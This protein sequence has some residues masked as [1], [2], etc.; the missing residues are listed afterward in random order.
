MTLK[1]ENSRVVDLP[2]IPI[3]VEQVK[4]RLGYPVDVRKIDNKVQSILDGEV[5]RASTLLK[6]K[7]VYRMFRPASNENGKMRFRDSE[8]IIRSKQVTRMLRNSDPVIL[9]MITIGPDLEEGVKELFARDEMAGA[10]ILDAIGSETADAAADE[11]HRVVLKRLAEEENLSVTPRFSPGYGDWPVTVQG[12][13]LDA[14]GGGLI[15][16]SVNESSLM[17]PRKSVSAVLGWVRK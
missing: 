1:D 3:P 13:F 15:G 5:K 6:P 10:V 8:F 17:I 14:C 4:K 16:I 12:D 7:G 9:F 2:D 11:M